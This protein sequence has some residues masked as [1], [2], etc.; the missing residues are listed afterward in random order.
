MIPDLVAYSSLFLARYHIRNIIRHTTIATKTINATTQPATIPPTSLPPSSFCSRFASVDGGVANISV[1]ELVIRFVLAVE[2]AL[3]LAVMIVV[4]P[5]LA[6][7]P[8]LAAEPMLAVEP[9]FA[10]ELAWLVESEVISTVIVA[11]ISNTH[12]NNYHLT[13]YV[14]AIDGVK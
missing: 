9:M 3:V 13:F 1:L 10:V 11:L 8:L 2:L 12:I 5:I 4:E 7:E 14:M 6:V